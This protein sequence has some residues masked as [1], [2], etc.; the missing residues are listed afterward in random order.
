MGFSLVA[1]ALGAAGPAQRYRFLSIR[2]VAEIGLVC[3][4]GALL[5][6]ALYILGQ[7]QEGTWRLASAIFSAAW[8][9]G[10]LIGIRRYWPSRDQA[11]RV[12]IFSPFA[13]LI[14]NA[15]L[16]WN[17]ILPPAAPG[18]YIWALLL[19]LAVAGLSFIAAVFH[20]RTPPTPQ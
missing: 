1:G 15:L 19:Y 9:T 17:V 7:S 3:L 16:W 2:D 18:R 4:A 14:G 8:C 13:A 20:E 12:L 10:S 6:S 11:P 5:P